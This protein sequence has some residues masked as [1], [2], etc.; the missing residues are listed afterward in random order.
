MRSTSEAIKTLGLVLLV[1]LAGPLLLGVAVLAVAHLAGIVLP[2]VGCIGALVWFLK[3][4]TISGP[5][6]AWHRHQ[7]RQQQ[8]RVDRLIEAHLA[9]HGL[10]DTHANRV[11]ALAALSRPAARRARR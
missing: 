6:R 11:Q 9:R 3:G 10:L 4:A 8:A 2:M 1:A 5:E 7:V